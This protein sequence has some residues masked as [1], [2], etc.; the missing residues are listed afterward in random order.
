VARRVS[1]RADVRLTGSS[2]ERGLCER[3]A[4]EAGLPEGSV[5]AGSLDLPGLLELV[6]HAELLV[7]GDTGVAHVATATGTP[8]VLLFGPV[9]P[10]YW[11]PVIDRGLHRVIWHGDGTGD[12]HA[13]QPDPALLR[14]TPDEVLAAVDALLPAPAPAR[15]FDF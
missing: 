10:D 9:S 3:V 7:C 6:A 15:T 1:R 8:S 5:V 4:S 11:G 13:R 2:G 14:I 12:P